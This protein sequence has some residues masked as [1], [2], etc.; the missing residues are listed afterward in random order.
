MDVLVVDDGVP[1]GSMLGALV[2][3]LLSAVLYDSLSNFRYSCSSFVM[4]QNHRLKRVDNCKLS[5]V[6]SSVWRCLA[7]LL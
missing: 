3:A 6:R 7:L 1:Q 4:P 2:E 5:S